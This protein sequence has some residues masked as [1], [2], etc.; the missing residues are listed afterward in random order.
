[1]LNLTKGHY[2]QLY[3]I[4][5]QNIRQVQIESICRRQIKGDPNGKFV[6]DKKENTVGKEEN[7][8]KRLFL[9]GH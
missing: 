6:L 2:I 1:M 5:R 8:F 3:S 4:K 7:V 9:Q